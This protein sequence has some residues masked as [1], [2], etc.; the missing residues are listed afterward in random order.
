MPAINA[1]EYDISVKDVGADDGTYKGVG[2]LLDLTGFLS[3]GSREVKVRECANI[4]VDD[5]K[6]LKKIKYSDA[7]VKYNFDPYDTAG[8]KALN[9]AYDSAK[10]VTIRIELDDKDDGGTHG[11]YIERDCL[12]KE[13]VSDRGDDWEETANLELLSAYRLT[14]KA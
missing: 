13:I 10:P 8:K 4:G 14:V 7:T 5:E 1:E 11:T 2:C 3:K 9:D 12:V 6:S